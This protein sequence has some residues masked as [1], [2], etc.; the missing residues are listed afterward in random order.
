MFFNLRKENET[1]IY[2]AR[3]SKA[4]ISI[5]EKKKKRKKITG[6]KFILAEMEISIPGKKKRK[7][8]KKERK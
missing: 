3:A 1:I 5:P 7:K 4:E 8:E 6:R 2:H